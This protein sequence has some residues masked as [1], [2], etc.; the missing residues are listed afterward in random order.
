M[1]EKSGLEPISRST[2]LLGQNGEERTKTHS[3]GYG[4]AQHKLEKRQINRTFK[5]LTNSSTGFNPIIKCSLA[6]LI[7]IFRIAGDSLGEN[8][9]AALLKMLLPSPSGGKS[10]RFGCDR[11]SRWSSRSIS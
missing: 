2:L 5:S 3:N 9:G 8:F 10:I 4:K 7:P 6:A 11:L 1:C